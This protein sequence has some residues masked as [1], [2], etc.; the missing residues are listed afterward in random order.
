MNARGRAHT[1]THQHT[2]AQN[3][4]Q[5]LRAKES[6][7]KFARE[8]LS[9]LHEVA[10]VQTCA[11]VY[12]CVG[13]RACAYAYAYAY[14]YVHVYVYMYV[15]VCV[16]VGACN[17]LSPLLLFSSLRYLT[18]CTDVSK[19]SSTKKRQKWLRSLKCLMLPMMQGLRPR[20]RCKVSL[21]AHTHMRACTHANLYHT[22]THVHSHTRTHKHSLTHTHI[23]ARV[24]HNAH[25]RTHTRTHAH[26]HAHTHK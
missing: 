4:L 2:K 21:C 13:V 3:F 18:A 7:R 17:P 10:M 5:G 15:Y 9:K 8:Y 25:T 26:T 20:S 11:Y 22:F 19:K 14:A 24:V 6:K 12:I 23:H 1:R 16:G